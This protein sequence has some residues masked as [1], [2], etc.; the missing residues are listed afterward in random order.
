MLHDPAVL[1]DHHSL[2]LEH[3]QADRS[4]REHRRALP[5]RPV[6]ALLVLP[7]ADLLLV[8]QPDHDRGRQTQVLL[9]D[10]SGLKL[11]FL[12]FQLWNCH[13]VD[14]LDRAEQEHEQG[15]DPDHDQGVETQR[16]QVRDF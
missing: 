9:R 7:P 2:L 5:R 14:R 1:P 8:Q 10:E 4:V 13:S 3:V 6:H 15:P 16:H 12:E 11:S